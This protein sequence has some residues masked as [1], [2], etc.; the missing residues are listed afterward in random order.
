MIVI[1]ACLI[2]VVVAEKKKGTPPPS[3]VLIDR[4]MTTRWRRL[5]AAATTDDPD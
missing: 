4:S 5:G 1:D 2:G 3:D